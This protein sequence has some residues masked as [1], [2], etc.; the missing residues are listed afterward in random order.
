MSIGK[1][2]TE[3]EQGKIDALK[4]EGYSNREVAKKIKRSPKVVNNYLRLGDKYGLKGRRGRKSSA[5]PILKKRIIHLACQESMS[6]AQIKD[7]LQLSQT[8]R[9]VRNI[10]SSSPTVIF[11]KFKSKPQLTEEHKEARLAFAK[12][13]IQNRVD[14]SKIIWSDEKKFNLDGPDGIRYYWH[15]LRYEPN[16]LSRRNFGGGTLMI[17]GAFIGNQLFDLVVV[18]TTM[19]SAK[20]KEMLNE[21]LLPFIKRGWTFMHDGAKIHQSIETKEWLNSN[22]I[23]VLEW[24]ANSPDLNPIENLW[25]TLT[26]AVFANGRQFKTKAEL[27]TE[28]FKQWALIKSKELS[29]LVGSMTDRIVE[30]IAKKGGNT[31]Y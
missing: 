18:E 11:K 24:P 25:G 1:R 10:L 13:S 20:Y 19:N 30:V 3:K 27:K 29:N 14:W 8:S 5:R 23:P 15:D 9:T 22:K 28:I 21:S 16:Y 7:E 26:R 4:R 6:S 31:K 12:R 2:L 17:W